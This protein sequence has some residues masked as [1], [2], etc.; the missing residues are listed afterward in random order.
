MEHA[1]VLLVAGDGHRAAAPVELVEDADVLVAEEQRAESRGEPEHFVEGQRDEVGV[2]LREVQAVGRDDGRGVER[3]TCCPRRDRG[4][5]EKRRGN[6]RL[7]L[8]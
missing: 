8:V 1:E 7:G 3:A 5:G 4:L 2:H 6:S